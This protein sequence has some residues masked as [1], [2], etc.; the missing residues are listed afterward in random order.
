MPPWRL[1]PPRPPQRLLLPAPSLAVLSP[2]SAM[3]SRSP[4]QS[5]SVSPAWKVPLVGVS[6]QKGSRKYRHNR[7]EPRGQKARSILI[8]KMALFDRQRIHPR[9]REAH[10]A[11]R[12]KGH[13]SVYPPQQPV[14][15]QSTPQQYTTDRA[16]RMHRW[17]NNNG[18]G[19]A[20]QPSRAL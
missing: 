11:T 7:G 2:P 19:T 12:N 20:T 16:Y 13:G 17:P 8:V 9:H 10:K 3:P 5:H 14:S 15:L 6:M 1:C 4:R 18:Y